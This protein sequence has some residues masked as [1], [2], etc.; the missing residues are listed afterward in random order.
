M[1]YIRRVY[2]AGVG[3]MCYLTETLTKASNKQ[4]VDDRTA[5]AYEVFPSKDLQENA[6]ASSS[7][8]AIKLV[9]ANRL[10]IKTQG[11][12]KL[13]L[14]PGV[15]KKEIS[16]ANYSRFNSIVK[17]TQLEG[18]IESKESIGVNYSLN[19]KIGFSDLK[20]LDITKFVTDKLDPLEILVVGKEILTTPGYQE[21]LLESEPTTGVVVSP[22]KAIIIIRGQNKDKVNSLAASIRNIRPYSVY[23]GIGLRLQEEPLK[24]KV[25]VKN[26]QKG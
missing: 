26:K 8:E 5:T 14:E 10:N 19:L 9:Q 3:Y 25:V 16:V 1:D 7:R 18:N 17:S 4:K 2:V 22:I 15:S 13:G 21:I 24:I 11:A 23:K 12:L 6:L 20:I